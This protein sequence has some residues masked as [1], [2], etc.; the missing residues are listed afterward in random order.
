MGELCQNINYLLL[1]LKLNI[2]NAFHRSVFFV[3]ST[4]GYDACRA[5]L[6]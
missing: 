6:F 4:T 1:Y 5:V 3:C 2:G